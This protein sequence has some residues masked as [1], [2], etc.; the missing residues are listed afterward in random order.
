[1]AVTLAETELSGYILSDS[2]T[3]I[4]LERSPR[5]EVVHM[6]VALGSAA[7]LVALAMSACSWQVVVMPSTVN[8]VGLYDWNT[9]SSV[10][11]LERDQT[12]IPDGHAAIFVPTMTDP[13]DEPQV[14]V[15][16]RDREVARGRTGRRIIVPPG[17]LVVRIGSGSLGQT[18]IVNLHVERGSTS[19]VRV[20]WGGL[21]VEVVDENNVP[22]RGDYELIRV[23][24]TE[25]MGVGSG[26]DALWGE[27]LRTWLLEPGLYRLVRRG[28]NY[29]AR[30]DFATVFIPEGGLV[31][32]KLVLDSITGSLR[33]AGVISADEMT[34]PRANVPWTRRM[35]LGANLGMSQSD[36]VPGA[37]DQL[38]LS[39]DFFLDS[40][41]AFER[42]S[43]S[44]IGILELEEGIILVSP[45]DA[46]SQ[47][48]QWSRDQLRVDAIY[49]YYLNKWLGPYI[50]FG[51]LTTLFPSRVI[52]TDDITVRRVFN[53]GTSRDQF[54]AGSDAYQTSRPFGSVQFAEGAGI[55][56]RLLRTSTIDANFRVG[57][58]F[59]QNL[60]REAFVYDD[61][62]GTEEV[63]YRQL[64]NVFQEGLEAILAARMRLFRFLTYT[65]EVEAFAGF[66]EF[67]DPSASWENTL[68]FRIASFASLDYTLDLAHQPLI[69]EDLQ[70]SQN[71]LLR[72]AWSIF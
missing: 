48:L 15:F 62:P 52:A 16:S 65:T 38:A 2:T 17:D 25:V 27:R 50:A 19:L 3:L 28:D 56:L 45:A 55:N 7:L 32:F 67:E 39:S 43:H 8:P 42:S 22:F 36:G 34:T 13:S 29:R 53:N 51:N 26:A 35:Y 12:P 47:P 61:L 41:V 9:E 18:T 5:H 57:A 4:S 33:G 30:T 46:E 31:R 20:R 70:F 60:F 37:A 66:S 40:Y 59:R 71:I 10:L 63:E 72:L 6:R 14:T 11:Q 54:V 21:I 64:E 68:S 23:E 58:G 1:V 69:T 49:T 24:D 44:F